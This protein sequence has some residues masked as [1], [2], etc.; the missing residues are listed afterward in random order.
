MASITCGG[1]GDT[2]E[3]YDPDSALTAWM[4]AQGADWLCA[5]CA[6]PDDDDGLDDE[7]WF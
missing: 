6:D 5:S 4:E 3:S 1:C 2:V 7:E